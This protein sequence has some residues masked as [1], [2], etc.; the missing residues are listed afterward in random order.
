MEFRIGLLIDRV[1]AQ[2]YFSL[3]AVAS[4][5]SLMW[6]AGDEANDGWQHDTLG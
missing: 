1:V 3:L 4:H 2:M 5:L 6:G